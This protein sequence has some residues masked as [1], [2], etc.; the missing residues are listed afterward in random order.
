MEIMKES[1][2][3]IQRLKHIQL[4]LFPEKICSAHLV[5]TDSPKKA[6]YRIW[7]ESDA[8]VFTVRKESG[9]KDTVLD[10]RAWSFGSLDAAEKLYDRRIKAKTNQE[11]KSPRKYALV[12]R[13]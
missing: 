11:R 9:A 3:K 5:A 13:T 6:F 8:G 2:K 12:Y 10:R 1:I 4:G 7:I